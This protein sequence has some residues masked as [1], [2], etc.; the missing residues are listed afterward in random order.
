M[1][2]T[3]VKDECQSIK[4]VTNEIGLF[5]DYYAVQSPIPFYVMLGL[6]VFSNM[7]LVVNFTGA[8]STMIEPVR[9]VINSVLLILCVMYIAFSLLLWKLKPVTGLIAVW[10]IAITGFNW[11]FIGQ[12]NEFFCTVIAIL[13]ALLAYKRDFKTIL[14]VILICHLATMLVAAVGLP[15]HITEL[16]Y[17]RETIDVVAAN[18]PLQSTTLANNI[19]FEDVGFSMGLVYPNH[20][21]RMAFLIFMIAWYL[22]GREKKLITFAVSII[23]S[24]IMWF[25]IVCKTITIF[26]IAFPICWIIIDFFHKREPKILI[27]NNLLKLWNGMLISMPF[28]CMLFTYVLGLNRLFFMKHWHFGQQIFALWMRFISAG[29]LF[30]TYGFPLLGRNIRD[31]NVIVETLGGYKYTAR[32]VD[33]AYV[34]YLIAIG[35]IALIACMLWIS[36]GNYRAIR[37]NDYAVL[38]MSVFLCVYGLIEIVFFQFEHNF[39]FFYPLTAT[40]LQYKYIN[41]K[42]GDSHLG[43]SATT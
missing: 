15:F 3:D 5:L 25:I 34:F 4:W 30:K 24:L 20:V 37:N 41:K 43:E 21:G 8:I 33:N 35:G 23:L 38:L 32:V 27:S 9:Y 42:N 1:S 28:L 36:L 22:W 31:E 11:N 17:K 18:I 6:F 29:I 40:A 13:L 14:K 39:M 16:V 26:F 7:L 19:D 10:L 2:G 12:T